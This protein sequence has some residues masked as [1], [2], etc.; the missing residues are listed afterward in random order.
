MTRGQLA[1]SQAAPSVTKVRFFRHAPLAFWSAASFL[2]VLVVAAAQFSTSRPAT[3]FYSNR[4]DLVVTFRGQ[5][6]DLA[7]EVQGGL[8]SPDSLQDWAHRASAFAASAQ[9]QSSKAMQRGWAEAAEAAS[10]IG[11]LT[12]LDSQAATR[13]LKR[14]NNAADSLAALAAGAA[15]AALPSSQPTE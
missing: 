15:P 9:G 11:E 13:A 5:V 2:L 4:P 7:L 12:E 6:K 10:A 3:P 1:L 8:A 14:V